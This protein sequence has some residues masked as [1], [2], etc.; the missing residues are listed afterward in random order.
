MPAEAGAVN[1]EPS[2]LVAEANMGRERHPRFGGECER[3]VGTDGHQG[4][5]ECSGAAIDGG[6][7][8]SC[9][10]RDES[11]TTAHKKWIAGDEE[12]TYT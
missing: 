7:R 4:A 5:I 11:I 12:R 6:H 8:V 1:Q 3:G 2:Q 10:K 9:G